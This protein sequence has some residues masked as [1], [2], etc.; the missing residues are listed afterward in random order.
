MPHLKLHICGDLEA[1]LVFFETKANQ[2]AATPNIILEGWVDISSERFSELVTSCAWIINTSFSEGGGG[3]T[4][5]CMAKGL[6][7]VIS[8]SASIT[9][10]EETGFYI[11]QNDAEHLTSLI[12]EVSQMP[13]QL[14]E[15]MSRHAYDFVKDNHTLENFRAKYKEFL[16][17][18][19]E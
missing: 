17:K 5:N 16:L 1:D 9:L 6:I 7:P 10:P 12:N 4:L 8:R 19:I 3:S 13:E 18:V 2:L 14:M 11:E 15:S